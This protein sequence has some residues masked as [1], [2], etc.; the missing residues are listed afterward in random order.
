MRQI[1]EPL[2]VRFLYRR[3]LRHEHSRHAHAPALLRVPGEER[4]QLRH[5]PDQDVGHHAVHRAV[6][7]VRGQLAFAVVRSIRAKERQFL[8]VVGYTVEPRVSSSRFHAQRIDV[9]ARRFLRSHEQRADREH[10]GP[11]PEVHDVLPLD[12]FVRVVPEPSEAQPG[13]G[14]LARAERQPG[15]EDDGQSLFLA[16]RE[17]LG[18]LRDDPQSVSHLDRDE[19]VHHHVHPVVVWYRLDDV[20]DR[21]HAQDVHRVGHDRVDVDARGEHGGDVA[22]APNLVVPRVQLRLAFGAQIGILDAA[23]GGAE[24]EE[25]VR[26]LADVRSVD[27]GDANLVHA[28]A[29]HVRVDGALGVQR[30]G[31]PR[32]SGSTAVGRGDARDEPVKSS[33]GGGGRASRGENAR[34]GRRRHARVA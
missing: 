34:R 12:A 28:P 14:V 32:L 10:P 13:R 19:R 7:F 8:R 24:G 20:L 6:E 1:V 15:L 4:R 9:H 5:R 26:Q 23:A 29:A 33:G 31:E 22:A 2:A 27:A 25:D 16:L 18:P 3:N 11:G 21:L 17:R 30:G